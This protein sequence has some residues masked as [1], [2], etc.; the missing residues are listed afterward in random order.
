MVAKD[1]GDLDQATV[2]FEEASRL[3]LESNS[4]DSA[5]NLDYIQCLTP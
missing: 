4:Q 3:Y 1:R 5:G 2:L